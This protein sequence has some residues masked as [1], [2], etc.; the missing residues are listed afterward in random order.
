MHS[1]IKYYET[2]VVGY[3]MFYPVLLLEQ[4]VLIFNVLI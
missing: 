2:K 3:G 4:A 1:D